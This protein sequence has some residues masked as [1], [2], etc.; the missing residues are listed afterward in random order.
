MY[1][2]LGARDY[3]YLQ[4]I[5]NKHSLRASTEVIATI[6]LPMKILALRYCT[7]NLLNYLN[8][9]VLFQFTFDY[10]DYK[11]NSRPIQAG[12]FSSDYGELACSNKITFDYMKRPVNVIMYKTN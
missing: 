1:E 2:I 8:Y 12:L 5:E 4:F 9:I 7:T 6:F 10:G 3:V 11:F